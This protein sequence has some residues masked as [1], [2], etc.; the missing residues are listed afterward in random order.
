MHSVLR[1]DKLRLWKG[2]KPSVQSCNNRGVNDSKNF[3]SFSFLLLVNWTF[4]SILGCICLLP[5]VRCK[6]L[7]IKGI[8][9]LFLL[10]SE[11]LSIILIIFWTST[12]FVLIS[13]VQHVSYIICFRTLYYK[14]T[15]KHN[16]R[17]EE[18]NCPLFLAAHPCYI[19]HSWGLWDM[20]AFQ[21]FSC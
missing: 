3:A 10:L 13:E 11:E 9:V 5:N 17:D 19:T 20:Y 15:A 21:L 2:R 8:H 6:G 16:N 1:E 7:E 4:F 14:H 12:C 18:K